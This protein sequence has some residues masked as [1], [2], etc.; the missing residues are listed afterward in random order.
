M[1]QKCSY[2]NIIWK[3]KNNFMIQKQIYEKFM[4]IWRTII[5]FRIFANIKFYFP[6]LVDN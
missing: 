6:F 3:Y 5:N 1:I 4:I 2:Y